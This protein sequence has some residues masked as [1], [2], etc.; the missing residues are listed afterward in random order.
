MALKLL[1]LPLSSAATEWVFNNVRTATA[2]SVWQAGSHLADLL[3]ALKFE[4][5]SEYD[6]KFEFDFDFHHLFMDMYLIC[7]KFPTAIY[8]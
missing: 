4:Y 6:S 5:D 2:V 1:H 3:Y 8:R 7:E